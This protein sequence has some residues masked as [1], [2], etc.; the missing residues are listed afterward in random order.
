MVVVEEEGGG[1][2]GKERS[3]TTLL[4]SLLERGAQLNFGRVL[5]CFNLA[6][7]TFHPTI[8]SD[9]IRCSAVEHHRIVHF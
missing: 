4:H 7:H 8:C 9:V 1:G 3:E 6:S 5:S 2:E